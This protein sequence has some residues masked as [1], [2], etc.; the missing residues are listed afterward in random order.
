[1]Q[2]GFKP[3][4]EA[5]PKWDEAASKALELDST[6][7]EIIGWNAISATWYEWNW[8]RAG[9]EYRRAISINPNY[10]FAQAYYSHYLAIIGRAEEG[11]SHG[12]LATKLDPFNSLY[13]SVHG[14][15]LKNARK[16]GE[17]LT[18]LEDLIR[19]EPDQGIGLPALWAVYHE[20]DRYD[21][22]LE[23]ARK[24]YALKG[25]DAMV[26]A[27][28]A[29]YMEGG[30]RMAMQRMA[31]TL[32]AYK[33]TTYIPNWQICTMCCRAEMKEE[34]LEWL[35]IAYE[36]H[37]PNI[38]YIPIDPL[39]DFIREEKRFKKVLNALNLPKYKK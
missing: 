2:H 5:M 9:K 27:L 12:E 15:A 23:T 28:E 30:Y 31:E 13:L 18:L 16:Y 37:D 1:M 14:Q 32:I 35:E 36:A 26:E 10:A 25:Q 3:A 39:F 6:L 34:A 24:I 33:D 20:L 7:V 17:A 4:N 21:D 11:L 22:A 19:D 8:D 38:P 29:G